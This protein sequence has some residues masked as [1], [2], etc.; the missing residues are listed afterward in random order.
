MWYITKITPPDIKFL[1]QIQQLIQ[2][3]ISLLS[4]KW[5][6]LC[7]ILTLHL[8]LFLVSTTTWGKYLPACH[9]T[10]KVWSCWPSNW[11][12]RLLCFRVFHAASTVF[13]SVPFWDFPHVSFLLFHF[14]PLFSLCSCVS[15]FCS[16]ARYLSGPRFITHLL[17]PSLSFPWRSRLLKVIIMFHKH[18]NALSLFHTFLCPYLLGIKV[19]EAQRILMCINISCIFRWWD[20]WQ[21][22]QALSKLDQQGV[23]QLFTKSKCQGDRGF[24]TLKIVWGDELKLNLHNRARVLL[25]WSTS[26]VGCT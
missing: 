4:D 19:K 16:V 5:I 2:S 12:A 15:M 11:N 9:T 17:F 13:Y 22:P 25:Q 3:N 26:Y 6:R 23:K 10:P 18:R 24:G 14:I 7:P 20:A 8:A 1:W 21:A